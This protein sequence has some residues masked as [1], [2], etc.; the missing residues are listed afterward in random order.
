MDTIVRND[1]EVI[2]EFR[3]DDDIAHAMEVAQK[4]FDYYGGDNFRGA[5]FQEDKFDLALH[6]IG[7]ASELA[8][9]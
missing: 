5:E 1:S 3:G 9:A 8:T 6:R 7:A 2:R 4:R